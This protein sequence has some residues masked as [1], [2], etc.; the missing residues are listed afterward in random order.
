MLVAL[1]NAESLPGVGRGME[2]KNSFHPGRL[3]DIFKVTFISI[4]FLQPPKT[5]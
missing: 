5:F 1:D 2:E 3:N 4:R